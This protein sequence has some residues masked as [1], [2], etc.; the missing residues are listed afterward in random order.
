MNG[1]L[2]FHFAKCQRAGKRGQQ[3]Q[4]LQILRAY[5]SGKIAALDRPAFEFSEAE[6]NEIGRT[7]A[8]VCCAD[9][10]A[11]FGHVGICGRTVLLPLLSGRCCPNA[12]SQTIPGAD[13]QSKD[14]MHGR[15]LQTF[16][17][18]SGR[19]LRRISALLHPLKSTRSG[20]SAVLPTVA[21]SWRSRS[22]IARQDSLQTGQ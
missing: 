2:A 16:S 15:D 14:V 13:Q 21:G 4:R 9:R 3:G 18:S 6:H 10:S 12:S 5:R 22:A 19:E 11:F 1:G 17:A 20:W 7:T 8:M